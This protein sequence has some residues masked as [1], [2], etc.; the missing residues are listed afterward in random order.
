MKSEITGK[1][2]EE[3]GRRF[4][5]TKQRVHQIARGEP[6]ASRAKPATPAT[7]RHIAACLRRAW[8]PNFAMTIDDAADKLAA[9]ESCERGAK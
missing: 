4:G 8:M 1:T 9:C 3:I 6:T 2:L 5:V 7:L